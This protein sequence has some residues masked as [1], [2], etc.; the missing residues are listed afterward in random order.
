MEV[1]GELEFPLGALSAE[2]LVSPSIESKY[3]IELCVSL[4]RK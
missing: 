1:T 4:R 3:V 2:Y